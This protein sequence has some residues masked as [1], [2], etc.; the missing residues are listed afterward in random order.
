MINS[1]KT[2]ARLQQNGKPP[3]HDTKSSPITS[4]T[5]NHASLSSQSQWPK[6]KAS[7]RSSPMPHSSSTS[8]S[9]Q[10]LDHTV[11][12]TT[13]RAQS[14]FYSRSTKSQTRTPE[15]A[16]LLSEREKPVGE[17]IRARSRRSAVT[18]LS[19]GPSFVPTVSKTAQILPGVSQAAG[20]PFL[21]IQLSNF[22][23]VGIPVFI[24]DSHV[25]E[26]VRVLRR[27]SC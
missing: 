27:W 24:V 22:I 7:S 8:S 13:A 18:P 1:A 26:V 23:L 25:M 2:S 6:T 16:E 12:D 11:R 3:I 5:I 14:Q 20:K 15:M 10:T 4:S 19:A 17:I 9:S 21:A